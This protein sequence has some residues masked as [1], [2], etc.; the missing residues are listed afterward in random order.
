MEESTPDSFE[1]KFTDNFGMTI[2]QFERLDFDVQEELIK[3]VVKLRAKIKKKEKRQISK[4]KLGEIL[5]YYP[6]FEK[7]SDKRKKLF[8]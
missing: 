6:I 5:S 7:T 4:L 1:R 2:D 8:K 3:K